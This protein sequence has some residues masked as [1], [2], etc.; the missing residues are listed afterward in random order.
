MNAQTITTASGQTVNTSFGG[1]CLSTVSHEWATRPDDERF[2]SLT[3][4]HAHVTGIRERSRAAVVANRDLTAVPV[5]GDHKGLQILGP[6]GK[7]TTAS[8]WAFGQL[9]TLAKAPASYLRTLPSPITADLINYGLHHAR[10]VE[11]C[12]VLLTRSEDGTSVALRAAT[13]PNYGRIWNSDLTRRL[14]ERFGDGLT[15]DFRVPGEFGVRVPVT[16]DNTTLFASDR[17]FFVFLCD[18]ENRIEIPNRRDG[19]SGSLARGFYIG[20]SETGAETL[21]FG[22]ML[23]DFACMNRNLW[24]VNDLTEIRIRHTKGAPHKLAEQMLPALDTF[25]RQSR[26]QLP[27]LQSMVEAAQQ[28]KVDDVDAFL[29]NRFSGSQ[30]NGIKAVHLLEEG[31]PMESLWD[32]SVGVTA[33]ARSVP[34]QND[35]IEIERKGGAILSMA[36]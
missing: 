20:N 36:A 12:G 2:T 8:N 28:K 23:F 30:A 33:Y 5:D 16:K 18:E 3:D 27:R 31:R 17:D 7:P 11:D 34:Y 9:A 13:G 25:V 10:D 29:K 6:T 19:R 35:R 24:G 1:Q 26:D 4:L 32:L 22:Q 15:G 14:C 21:V